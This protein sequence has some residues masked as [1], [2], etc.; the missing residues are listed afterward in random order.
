MQ[1]VSQTSAPVRIER[2][3]APAALLS[4]KVQ[5]TTSTRDCCVRL[6]PDPVNCRESEPA[7]FPAKRQL[8]TVPQPLTMPAAAAWLVAWLPI[9]EVLVRAMFLNRPMMRRPVLVRDWF[10]L[11]LHWSMETET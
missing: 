11:K 5:L 3:V 9:K 2:A 6:R 8:A 4:A 10:S 1:F 7:V